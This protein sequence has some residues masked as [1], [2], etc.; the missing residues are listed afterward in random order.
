MTNELSIKWILGCWLAHIQIHSR[1]E[2][3]YYLLE[4]LFTDDWGYYEIG[5]VLLLFSN[6][7]VHDET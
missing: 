2:Q 7:L 1:G 5:R 6:N 4:E 3:F